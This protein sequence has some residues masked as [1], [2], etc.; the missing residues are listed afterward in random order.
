MRQTN[1]SRRELLQ[2]S[3]AAL[4]ASTLAG[5]AGCVGEVPLGGTG[6]GGGSNSQY[7]DWLYEPGEIADVDQYSFFYSDIGKF[8]GNEDRIDDDLYD[9]FEQVEDAFSGADIDFDEMNTY[10]S[11]RNASIAT[12]S[13]S[14]DD[15]TNELED[16]DFDDDTEHEGYT[17]YL[18][19]DEARAI[20]V[21]DQSLVASTSSGSEG[22]TDA[23]ETIID[24]HLGAVDR[25]VN[26]NDELE[27]LT[28][29]LGTGAY[30]A[31]ETY[32]EQPATDVSTG[33]FE[34]SVAR[35]TRWGINGET[36]NIKRVIVFEEQDDVDTD[37]VS[38][39]VEESQGSDQRYDDVDDTS[40]EQKD[41]MAI[42]RGTIDTDDLTGNEL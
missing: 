1:P 10:L 6:G 4:G 41:R 19:S 24:T 13:Y 7:V 38:G 16:N 32:E 21:S 3:G 11:Y 23:V 20:G 8:V 27:I 15:I 17:I 25:Y 30:V 22:A 39:W 9:S 36:S 12:G 35:G 2:F 34:N 28:T 40:V 18:S 33:A 14:T 29:S 5:L 26:E 42:I 37:D 31:G